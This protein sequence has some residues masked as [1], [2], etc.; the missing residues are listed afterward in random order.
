MR[1]Q[2]KVTAAESAV[3]TLITTYIGLE[4]YLLKDFGSEIVFKIIIVPK[5]TML[6][7]YMF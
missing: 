4:H 1:V 3:P 5:Q 7:Y 6:I 2:I